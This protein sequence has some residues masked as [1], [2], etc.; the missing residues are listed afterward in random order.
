MVIQLVARRLAFLVFVLFGIS[1]ITFLLSHVV[2][3]DPVRLFAGP[4]AS[5]AAIDQIRHQ[6]GFD[7]PVWQQ[8]LR[9]IGGILRGD[10]GYSLT[11]HRDVA[12]DLHD[13]LP[14]TIELTLTAIVMILA[15]GI[16]LEWYVLN[17]IFLDEAGYLFPVVI[18]WAEAGVIAV[19]ALVMAT[20]AGLLP[21]L[22]AVRQRIPEAIAY[23]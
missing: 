12:S 23:E 2:P 16:P 7:L 22:S 6:Y 9:Y 3:T 13:Y 19:A 4:R 18:P 15:V 11:S 10:F 17:V 21:A 8:Y 5:K 14:A 20:L 1:L